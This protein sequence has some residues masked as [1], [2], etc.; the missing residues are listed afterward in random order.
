MLRKGSGTSSVQVVRQ[1]TVMQKYRNPK[2]GWGDMTASKKTSR[3]RHAESSRG[4]TLIEVMIVVGI[5]AILAATAVVLYAPM[6]QKACITIVRYDLKKFFEAEQIQL[7]ENSAFVGT[8]GD[9]ISN[10]PG[11]LSTFTLPD[12]LP[13][14]N[15]Y[16]TITSDDPFTAEARQL[17]FEVVFECDVQTGIIT[18][19]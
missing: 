6:R 4:F 5:I 8:T 15:T 7:T 1:C 12:Y 13:S 18:E 17:G 10:A 16:I 9:I 11:I 2:K 19:R 3:V 14:K